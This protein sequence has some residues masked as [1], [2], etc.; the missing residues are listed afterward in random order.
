MIDC[1]DFID[2]TPK[3]RVNALFGKAVAM[4]GKTPFDKIRLVFV[5]KRHD[6]PVRLFLDSVRHRFFKC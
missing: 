1:Q 4:V 3:G 6:T 2:F 5:Q